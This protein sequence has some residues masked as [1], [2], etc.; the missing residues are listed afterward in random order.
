MTTSNNKGSF[1]SGNWKKSWKQ[2][3]W[4]LYQ[5]LTHSSEKSNSD[6]SHR[7][8]HLDSCMMKEF[9]DSSQ[10][11]M[12][13]AFKCPFPHFCKATHAEE[14]RCSASWPPLALLTSYWCCLTGFFISASPRKQMSHATAIMQMSPCSLCCQQRRESACCQ[15]KMLPLFCYQS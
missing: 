5:P 12:F 3:G 4:V 8:K 7:F 15:H 2:I 10:N 9:I 13:S 1:S 11:L 6:T 14:C